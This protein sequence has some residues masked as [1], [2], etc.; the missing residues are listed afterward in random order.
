MGSSP[1]L[2]RITFSSC[3]HQSPLTIHLAINGED[4]VCEIET[5]D[6][7]QMGYLQVT[8]NVELPRISPR[9]SGLTHTARYLRERNRYALN[10]TLDRTTLAEATELV[11]QLFATTEL[12]LT[13]WYTVGDVSGVEVLLGAKVAQDSQTIQFGLPSGD[14]RSTGQVWWRFAQAIVAREVFQKCEHIASHKD[15]TVVRLLPEVAENNLE[16]TLLQLAAAFSL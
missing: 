9:H 12:E 10:W 8:L 16:D 13:Y 1:Y 6:A 15:H 4:C 2:S 3:A 11:R 14:R 5:A 7:L